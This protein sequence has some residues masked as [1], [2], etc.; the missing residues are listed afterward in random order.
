[1][2]DYE[3]A[4]KLDPNYT[5][6]YYN[7]GNANQRLNDYESAVVNYSQAIELNPNHTEAYW[8]RG[9]SYYNLGKFSESLADFE[10]YEKSVGSENTPDW[11]LERINELESQGYGR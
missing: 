6:A 1:V 2:S 11:M 10:Y 5:E 7:L 3:Q 8:G 9:N 4:I